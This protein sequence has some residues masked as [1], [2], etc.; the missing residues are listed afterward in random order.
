MDTPH[1]KHLLVH[2]ISARRLCYRH[3]LGIVVVVIDMLEYAVE[4]TVDM[5][6]G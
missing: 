6:V 2:S 4:G 5:W 1:R 3:H